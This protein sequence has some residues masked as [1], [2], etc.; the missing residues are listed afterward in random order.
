MQGLLNIQNLRLNYRIIFLLLLVFTVFSYVNSLSCPFIWDD[1][2][3]IVDNNRIR[4]FK[5]IHQIFAKESFPGFNYYRPIQILTYIFDYRLWKLN[6]FGYHLSN[7]LLHFFSSL[8]IFV[9]LNSTLNHKAIS[10]ILS[11]LY[12]VH[13]INTS[14]V[15]YIS[16]R[17]DI[18]AAIFM[19][20]SMILFIRFYQ[21]R[22]KGIYYFVS[23]LFFILALLSKEVAIVFP[24]ILIAYILCSRD[25]SKTF[26]LKLIYLTGYFAI[27]I[28]YLV[29]RKL[30]IQGPHLI[31]IDIN[32][33][34]YFL[35]L[36]K[37]ILSYASVFLFPYNLHMGRSIL[38]ARSI[39]EPLT[40]LSI[41]T[42]F[43]FMVAIKLSKYRSLFGFY[44]L[45][46]ILFIVPLSFFT[47]TH[48]DARGIMLIPEH[49]LYIPA[50]GFLGI[51]GVAIKK[52]IQIRP[53]DS[54]KIIMFLCVPIF[55]FLIL[56]ICRNIEWQD[57]ILFYER[58][59]ASSRLSSFSYIAY[60][61]L[62][63]AYKRKGFYDKALG[64][65]NKALELR[66]DS[67]I[68]VN[69]GNVYLAK[70][71][72]P[73]AIAQYKK[74]ME[75]DCCSVEAHIALAYTYMRMNKQDEA[76]VILDRALRLD[77]QNYKI[78]EMFKIT[79]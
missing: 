1:Y 14:V 73:K 51:L 50:V 38:I 71:N 31:S 4:D 49:W 69:I 72:F 68:Y 56:T 57:E 6:P 61:N 16:G 34:Q 33:Y 60:T 74:A 62:G 9:L 64:M 13:P 28:A 40:I 44:S 76:K 32:F 66:S 65:L 41:I 47:F 23:I 20:C 45:W 29:G 8:L 2:H 42:I 5:N 63:V 53:S 21:E 54:K 78:R 25:S 75:I 77:P 79:P 55:V 27:L 3:L 7:V 36:F 37:A 11:I 17:A 59:L 35:T 22:L 10:L 39:F 19:F 48:K 12:A 46:I 30:I 15:T 26:F 67:S 52:L 24:F 70:A 58:M 18:L 43:L